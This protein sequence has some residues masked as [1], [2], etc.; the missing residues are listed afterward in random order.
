MLSDNFSGIPIED[1]HIGMYALYTQT[2]TDADIKIFSGVSG[3]KN[4]IHMCDEYAQRSRY[5]K[6][7]AHGMMLA[8]YFSSLFG[9]KLPGHGSIYVSQSLNFKRPIYIDDTVTVKVEVADVNLIKRRV[10]F[11]TTCSVKSKVVIDGV[12][13][14]YIPLVKG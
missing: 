11:K 5:K 10:Y 3:D 12:A 6:R 2:I 8:S 14:I 9:T 7:I 1:I 13:E 4:P